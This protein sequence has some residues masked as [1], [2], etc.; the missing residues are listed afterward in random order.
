MPDGANIIVRPVKELSSGNQT[1]SSTSVS[2]KE[3]VFVKVL[4]LYSIFLKDFS[5]VL[6]QNFTFLALFSF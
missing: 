2:T 5:F 1:P 3:Y 6:L 4:S